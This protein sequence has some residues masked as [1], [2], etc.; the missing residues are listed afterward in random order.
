VLRSRQ[1]IFFDFEMQTELYSYSLIHMLLT[2]YS[3]SAPNVNVTGVFFTFWQTELLLQFGEHFANLIFQ[4]RSERLSLLITIWIANRPLATVLCPIE[5]RNRGNRAPT[6]ATPEATTRKNTG[7]T[8][9]FAREC[10]HPWIH[11]F[12]IV[13][14]L[15]CLMTGGWHDGV[16][17]MMVWL[18]QNVL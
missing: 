8:Q 10:F 6:S 18:L 3:K 13:R 7:K 4:K 9:G 15:N 17:D 2:S 12:P 5:A 16:A 11:T 1:F 14:R